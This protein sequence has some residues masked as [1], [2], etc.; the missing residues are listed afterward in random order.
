[1]TCFFNKKQ[2]L[3]KS[4]FFPGSILSIELITFLTFFSV[5]KNI[6]LPNFL[7][8]KNAIL[9][10]TTCLKI[11]IFQ[12][13]DFSIEFLILFFDSSKCRKKIYAVQPIDFVLILQ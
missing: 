2:N 3:P 7:K 8:Y 12:E 6:Y 1:M 9:V 13:P 11:K 5:W 10:Y 4:S